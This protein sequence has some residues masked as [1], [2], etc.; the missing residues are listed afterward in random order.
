MDGVY[1]TEEEYNNAIAAAKE[2]YYEKLERYSSQYTIAINADS[3]IAA[4]SWSGDF[5]LMQTATSTWKS[6]VDTYLDQ[7]QTSFAEW[8]DAID[9]ITD[10]AGL[11]LDTLALKTGAITTESSLLTT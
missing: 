1:K 5:Q 7:C 11:D 8:K 9:E 6:N 3:A 10:L 2:Y 4:E